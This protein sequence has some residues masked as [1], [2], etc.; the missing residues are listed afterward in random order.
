MTLQF[1]GDVDPRDRDRVAETVRRAAGGI[2][3]FTLRAGELITL[4]LPPYDPRL[5]AATT[6]APPPLLELQRRL[7]ARLARNPRDSQRFTPHLTLARF[8]HG[9]ST[10][11]IRTPLDPVIEF[12]IT[13]VR[14]MQS[15]LKPT[16]AE[17]RCAEAVPLAP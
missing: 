17:H 10:E 15:I 14:L 3:P 5:I 11:P 2:P 6:G 16:G 7:A 13:E 12:P 8:D 9:T 1:I 4:P